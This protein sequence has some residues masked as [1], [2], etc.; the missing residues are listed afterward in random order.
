MEVIQLSILVTLAMALLYMTRLE[1]IRAT[2][3]VQMGY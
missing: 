2:C 3:A 1:V